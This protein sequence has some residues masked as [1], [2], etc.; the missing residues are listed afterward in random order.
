LLS[1]LARCAGRTFVHEPE[2]EL[3]SIRF[4]IGNLPNVRAGSLWLRVNLVES[5]AFSCPYFG[6]FVRNE[7]NR[8]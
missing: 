4:R 8:E 7:V 2:Q 1:S 6:L 3:G 5:S